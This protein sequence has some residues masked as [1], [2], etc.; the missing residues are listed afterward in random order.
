MR[1][2]VYM[3]CMVLLFAA[4]AQAEPTRVVIHVKSKDGKFVGSSM[5]GVQ[6]VVRDADTSEILAKGVTAGSTG[7]TERIMKQ[8]HERHR[9]LTSDDAARF[10]ATLEID[11]PARVEIEAYGPLAQRQAANRTTVTQWIFPGEH[12][13]QGD[14]ILLD[15][16]GFVVDVL[17]PPVHVQVQEAQPI[18]LKAAVMMMCGCP[19]EPDGI[20]DAKRYKIWAEVLKNGVEHER[21]TMSYAG[22][23]SQ[24]SG[25]FTPDGPG[26][27]VVRVMA[28]DP[29][30]GNSGMDM[31]TVVLK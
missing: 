15:L 27:Y 6:I 16:A 19:V 28:L 10:V 2:R 21:L 12:I 14:G 20:W 17:A 23:P 13:E 18:E 3:V 29:S 31:T 8:P 5:G 1:M 22:S 9:H 30:N 11:E 25:Q 4:L 26:T 7:D 24:F